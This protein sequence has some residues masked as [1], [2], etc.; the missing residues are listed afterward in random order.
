[1]QQSQMQRNQTPDITVAT[2]TTADTSGTITP[3]KQTMQG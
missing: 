2:I 1:M 3:N